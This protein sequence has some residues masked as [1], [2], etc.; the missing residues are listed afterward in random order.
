[1]DGMAADIATPTP[2]PTTQSAH[3]DRHAVVNI[4]TVEG[5]MHEYVI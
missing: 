1:M 5:T 3:M 2:C 4:V